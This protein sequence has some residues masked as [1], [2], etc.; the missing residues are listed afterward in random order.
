M[1]H[2][3]LPN[4]GRGWLDVV[5]NVFLIREPREML[6]SLIRVT[7]NIRV[8][9]TG[10]PQQWELFEQVRSHRAGAPVLD[11][12]DVLENPHGIL[13]RLCTEIGVPF[14]ES[15]LR[16]RAGP[17]DTDGVWAKHWY[18]AVEKSTGFQPY[19]P[20]PDPVPEH[21]GALHDECRGYYDRLYE[22]RLLE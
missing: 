21:L 20:K 15:M 13:N 22:H 7:P 16:W 8:E 9:D 5:T 12:K 3:L 11:A 2:H 4:M 1:A 14:S 17:R 10:L 6:T 18:D 19:R